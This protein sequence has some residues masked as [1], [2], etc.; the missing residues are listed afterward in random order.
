MGLCLCIFDEDEEIDGV[1]VGHYADFDELRSYVS[2]EL[3]EGKAGT[4]FPTFILHSDC[5]GEWSPAESEKLILELEEIISQMTM[6][7]PR[8]FVSEWQRLVAKSV[9]LVPQNAFESFIDVDGQFVLERI[10]RLAVMGSE[11]RLPILF[12]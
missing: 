7:P 3:E 1:E 5:D 12:Q 10:L 2:R 11:R 9:G 4:R 6:R 8:E